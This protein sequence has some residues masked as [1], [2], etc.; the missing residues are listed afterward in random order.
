[1]S[2]QTPRGRGASAP[3][4]AHRLRAGTAIAVL[5]T[6]LVAAAP[7]AAAT[8]THGEGS[9]RRAAS[10]SARHT[11][12][13]GRHHRRPRR[14]KVGQI[15]S[16]L[17]LGSTGRTVA[18][19]QR[20]LHVRA[21]GL[22][23]IRTERVVLRFQRRRHLQVDGI[24]GPQTWDALFHLRPAQSAAQSQGAS[25]APAVGSLSAGSSTA[26]AGA[27]AT[28]GSAVSGYGGA[29]DYTIPASIVACES[30][31]NY[32][33]VNPSTGAGGAYQIMPS[34]WAAFGGQGLPE[35]ASP[36]E[37]NAIAAQIWATDG[38]SAWSC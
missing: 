19:L 11:E 9:G 10:E 20:A 1:L 18:E 29:G 32:S 13:A 5:G 24:V 37:Q 14:P 30:G 16:D 3:V 22:Y 4:K 6:S 36:A 25:G 2:N 38:P 12:R 8:H 27:A 21:S 17:T 35:N 28:T 23:T 7:A 34:T 15:T 33:A 31:G 26:G